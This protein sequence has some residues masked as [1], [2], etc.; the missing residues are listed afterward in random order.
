MT[1]PQQPPDPL[2]GFGGV[3]AAVLVLEAV[4]VALALLVL[5]KGAPVGAGRGVLIGVVAVALLVGASV[6]RRRW[7][8]AVAVG[9]QVV[10]IAC[11]FAVVALGVLGLVFGAVFG[12][13]LWMRAQVLRKAAQRPR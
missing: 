9:L 13:L 5:G 8:L 6:Q 11:W 2:R 4:V 3:V 1:G 10:V 12:V 7:G